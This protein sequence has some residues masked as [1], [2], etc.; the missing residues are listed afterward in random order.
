MYAN[1]KI[2]V[3]LQNGKN[4]IGYFLKITDDSIIVILDK[5]SRRIILNAEVKSIRIRNDHDPVLFAVMLT[6]LIFVII[7]ASGTVVPH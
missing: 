6:A 1:K 4:I 7:S 3:Q 5:K 2:T